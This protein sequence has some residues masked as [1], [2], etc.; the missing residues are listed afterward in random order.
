MKNFNYDSYP[1]DYQY[2][3]LKKGGFIKKFWHNGKLKLIDTIIEIKKNDILL[4]FGCGSGNLCFHLAEKCTKIFG[5]DTKQDAIQFANSLKK[6]T[7]NNCTFLGLT[8]H[9]LPFEDSYFDKIF[10][11]DVIEHIE[12]PQE[13]LSEIRRVLKDEGKLII[14]TPN[15]NSLWPILEF[16]ADLIHMSPDN[17]KQHVT[18]LTKT[19]CTE[20]LTECNFI[21]QKI[22]T[23][24]SLSPFISS[25]NI[26]W[27]MLN[28]EL[29]NSSKGMLIF[30]LAGKKQNA[31]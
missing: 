3:A 11:L 10:L 15:Y 4:D 18:R 8:T 29:K 9:H 7:R 17:G 5:V 13:V 31:D 20:L 2:N 27:K 21:V 1:G 6:T 25:L 19:K 26:A 30:I 12:N 23:I 14:T 24:Y 16:F 28:W 22:G